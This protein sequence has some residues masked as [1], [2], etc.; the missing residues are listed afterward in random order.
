MDLLGRLVAERL[1]SALG[2]VVVVDNRG[3]AGEILGADAV[4]KGQG[5]GPPL[6]SSA[7]SR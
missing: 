4:A 3:G 2:Q 1:G 7:E 6:A 5:M